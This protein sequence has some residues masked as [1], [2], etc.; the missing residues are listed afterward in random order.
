MRPPPE[1]VDDDL[2]APVPAIRTGALVGY[3]RVSTKGQLLDRQIHA[4][5]EAGCIRIFADK[6]SGKNTER[7]LTVRDLA[8]VL[9]PGA[10]GMEVPGLVAANQVAVVLPDLGGQ[11]RVAHRRCHDEALGPLVA[12][13]AYRCICPLLRPCSTPQRPAWRDRGPLRR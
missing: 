13:R 2:L 10:D 7:V 1:P 6:K 11:S 5:T 12:N 4:L 8:E 3:A 9:V